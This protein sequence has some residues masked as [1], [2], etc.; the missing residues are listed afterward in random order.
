MTLVAAF[1]VEGRPVPQ[2]SKQAIIIWSGGRKGL[3]EPRAVLVE[4]KSSRVKLKAWRAA[5]AKVAVVAYTGPIVTEAVD[6]SL[7]FRLARPKTVT[8]PL[9]IVAPD[10]DKMERAVLDALTGSLIKDDA[11]VVDGYRRKRYTLPGQPEG[12]V[13]TVSLVSPPAP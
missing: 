12:V 2:G 7:S 8:R 6:V 10:V 4:D 11:Q 9:P 13:I 3:G 1:F 5:I